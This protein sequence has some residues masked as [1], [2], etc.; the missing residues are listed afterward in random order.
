MEEQEYKESTILKYHT[1]A[2]RFLRSSF[3][4]MNNPDLKYQIDE[5]L[6]KNESSL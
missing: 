5:F 4:D 3:Y 6:K 2:S 1:Y